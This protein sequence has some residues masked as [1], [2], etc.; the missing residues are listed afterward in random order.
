MHAQHVCEKWA[1]E[2]KIDLVIL[3]VPGIYGPGRVPV[4]R[5]RSG[6]VLPPRQYCGYTNR[7]H[8]D[9]LVAVMVAAAEQKT[10]GIFNVSD[11]TPLRMNDYFDL[12]AKVFNLC[13]PGTSEEA[14]ALAD[15]S[16][17]LRSYLRESRKIDNTKM[18][19]DLLPVLTYANVKA[20]LI[21]CRDVGFDPA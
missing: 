9:D 8:V 17:G 6:I 5:I 2:F 3:R 7:I 10:T 21:A 1:D 12:V 15:L 13:P 16:P 11:G 14:T 4:D 18:L 19:N 20:G